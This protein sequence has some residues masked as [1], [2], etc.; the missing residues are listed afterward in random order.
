MIFEEMWG[1]TQNCRPI[2][3]NIKLVS[4]YFKEIFSTGKFV[5]NL[6]FLTTIIDNLDNLDNLDKSYQLSGL[7]FNLRLVPGISRLENR[8]VYFDGLDWPI[9]KENLWAEK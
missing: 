2:L 4:Q 8:W 5:K 3:D 7:A 9:E 6:P 1:W